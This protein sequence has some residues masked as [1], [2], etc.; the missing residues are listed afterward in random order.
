M[1]IPRVM[2]DVERAGSEWKIRVDGAGDYMMGALTLPDGREVPQPAADTDAADLAR[3]LDR[4]DRNTTQAGDVE[5]YGRWLF[6]SLLAPAW[7]EIRA[8]ADVAATNGVELALHWPMEESV[9]HGLMWETMHDGDVALAGHTAL[10]VAITRIVP[11]DL[12]E[13]PAALP[14]PPRMLLASGSALTDEVIRP[15]AMVMGLVRSLETAGMCTPRVGLHLTAR[16]LGDTCQQF[17]PDL[18]HLVAHGKRTDE[19]ATVLLGQDRPTGG[20][21]DATQ[22]RAALTSGGSPTMVVLSVCGSGAGR[23][24]TGV[25]SLAQ[26]LVAG[27]IPVVVAM[28]GEVSEQACRLYTTKLFQA[29]RDG[30]PLIAAAARGRR[31]ALIGTPSAAERLDWAMPAIFV[32]RN[33]P[34]RLRLADPA[35]ARRLGTIAR[36]LELLTEPVFIGRTDIL[37]RLD[38]TFPVGDK[39]AAGFIT[40]GREGAI[41]SLGGTRLLRE[42]GHRMIRLG[43]IPLLLGPFS[44]HAPGSL[45]DVVVE[46]F[47]KVVQFAEQTGFRLPPSRLLQLGTDGPWVADAEDAL[48]A[49]ADAIDALRRRPDPDLGTRVRSE[50]RMDLYALA[51]AAARELG[52]PF[53]AHTTPVLLADELH[54]WEGAVRPL[55][56]LVTPTGLGTG[57]QPVPVLA[58]ASLLQRDGEAIKQFVQ[59]KHNQPGYRYEALEALTDSEAALG[60][61]WVLLR[62]WGER[63]AYV[64]PRTADAAAVAHS[65][66]HL[67][68][69]PKA[70]K[71]NLYLLANLCTDSGLLEKIEDEKVYDDHAESY[72]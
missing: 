47:S 29:V 12:D 2:I 21:A 7:A 24:G 58:T 64:A 28:N 10:L 30:E 69:R 61:Q 37:S 53:G 50:L 33:V 31:A 44:Q 9:L 62:P 16:E 57:A 23:P 18:V 41:A 14:R 15:G 63:S 39:P 52:E 55:L 17:R 34:P 22:L 54:R 43:H 6:D 27:Q 13:V 5:R 48:V 46:I 40:I 35:A 3:L 1:T 67:E 66:R 36:D 60:F 32:A 19:G 56:A 71:D 49:Y 68:G 8:R 26:E 59:D 4:V 51:E 20:R 42:A 25:L 65:F 72:R 38:A 11:V 45:R 70:V